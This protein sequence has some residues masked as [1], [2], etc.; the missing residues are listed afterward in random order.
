MDVHTFLPFAMIRQGLN[1]FR[2]SINCRMMLIA[3]W[4]P[5]REWFLVLL[6]LLTEVPRTLPL[7]QDLL[8]QPVGRLLHQNLPTL[9][10]I[11]WRLSSISLEQENFCQRCREQSFLQ[12]VQ[13][14]TQS[15][16]R[17]GPHLLN[18]ADLIRCQPL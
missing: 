2:K 8:S 10:L 3:P 11:G 16:C 12:G 6:Q 9:H 18:G 4:W 1:K 13:L 7:R 14:L 5:Q 15:T 17:D